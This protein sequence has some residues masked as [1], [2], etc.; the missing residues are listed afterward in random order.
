MKI[1]PINTS[2]F[3]LHFQSLNVLSLGLVHQRFSCKGLPKSSSLIKLHCSP[4]TVVSSVDEESSTTF[5]NADEITD[6]ILSFQYLRNVGMKS[7]DEI[8]F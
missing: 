7:R 8:S 2:A 6:Q 1:S 5:F 4:G 3:I